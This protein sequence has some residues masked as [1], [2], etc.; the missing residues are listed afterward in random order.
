V[1]G[2]RGQGA[3][4]GMVLGSVSTHCVS[5]ASCPVVVVRHVAKV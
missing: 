1:V 2:S 3:L 4:K 5:H